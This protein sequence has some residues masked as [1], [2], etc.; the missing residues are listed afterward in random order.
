MKTYYYYGSIRKTIIQFLDLW[1]NITIARYNSSGEVT[2]YVQVPLKFGTKE[3]CWYWINEK[4]NDE[5]LPMI[6]VVLS[7]V[8]YDPNR[9]GNKHHYIK[10]TTDEDDGTTGRFLN[11]V[12][13]NIDFSMTIWSLHMADVDQILEQILPFFSPHVTIRLAISELDVTIDVPVT[14]NSCTPDNSLEMSD[15]EHRIVKWTLD[16]SV[17]TWLFK[18]LTDTN[19]ILKVIQKIYTN[20]DA[21]ENRFTEST[22]TSGAP[23]SYESVALFAKAVAPWFD[24]DEEKLI[25][26]ERFGD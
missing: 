1:N 11:P 26:Y 10:K 5:L 19:I 3:K 20:E 17:A 23:G 2:R 4:K 18:P 8:T 21:W 16:F 13:Y 6:S 7:N 9:A 24:D 12:P 25:V 15:E 22:F 14:F